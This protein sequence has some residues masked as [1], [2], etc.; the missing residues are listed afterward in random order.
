MSL[1]QLPHRGSEKGPRQNPLAEPH[2]QTHSS[3]ATQSGVKRTTRISAAAATNDP[4]QP[5]ATRFWCNARRRALQ[6]VNCPS[7]GAI[8]IPLH[9]GGRRDSVMPGFGFSG[10]GDGAGGS[11][12]CLIQ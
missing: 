3:F 12:G 8:T 9:A 1:P 6:I 5:F 11:T 4:S 10:I 2:R 7:H